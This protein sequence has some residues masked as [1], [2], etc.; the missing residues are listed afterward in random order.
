MSSSGIEVTSSGIEV[1]RANRR[2]VHMTS[3]LRVS[4]ANMILTLSKDKTFLFVFLLSIL[5]RYC[6]SAEVTRRQYKH[7]CGGEEKM[8]NESTF[9]PSSEGL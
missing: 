7:V 6:S 3:P 9:S 2:R 5:L 4:L 8:V 1:S